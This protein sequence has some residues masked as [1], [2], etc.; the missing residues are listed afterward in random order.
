LYAIGDLS[1]LRATAL[2]IVG[3]RH[4]SQIGKE[5]AFQF[6]ES[7]SNAGVT[8]VSG[9]AIGIDTQAHLGALNGV[10]STIAVMGTGADLIYPSDNHKLAQK[11]ANTGLLLTEFPLST[12]PKAENFPRR[13]RI[14]SGLSFGCLVVEAAMSSGSLITSRFSLE[15]GKDV[16]AIPGSI[17]NPQSKGCH[18]LIKQGAKLVDSITDI[19]E[20]IA[21]DLPEPSC[22][23]ADNHDSDEADLADNAIDNAIQSDTKPAPD[24]AN[25]TP[26]IEMTVHKAFHLYTAENL[27]EDMTTQLIQKLQKNQ[28]TPKPETAKKISIDPETRKLS[29]A[30]QTPPSPIHA[31]VLSAMGND[32]I[33]I[34]VLATLLDLNIATLQT[35]LL[36]LELFGLVEKLLSGQYRRS[37]KK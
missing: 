2:A 23:N 6:A 15:Q 1:L 31:D 10:G 11:I 14:I 9:L 17:H 19:L 4:P 7:L 35:K 22:P 3:S 18:Q 16:F 29:S 37:T 28:S 34:D 21:F 12:A 25:S 36:E 13:N 26:I 20:E 30:R 5:N 27:A 33:D 8:I 32:P 24:H